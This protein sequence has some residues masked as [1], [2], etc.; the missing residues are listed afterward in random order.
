MSDCPGNKVLLLGRT[1][2]E[3]TIKKDMNL[4]LFCS[5]NFYIIYS[6]HGEHSVV[7]LTTNEKDG[8]ICS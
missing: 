8:I 2:E 5:C 7:L 1:Q 3:I 6:C 4:S